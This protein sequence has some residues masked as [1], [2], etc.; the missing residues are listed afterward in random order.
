MEALDQDQTMKVQ[1]TSE[2][3]IPCHTWNLEKS[4]F[5]LPPLPPLPDLPITYTGLDEDMFHQETTL[6]KIAAMDGNIIGLTNKGHLVKY[7]GLSSVQEFNEQPNQPTQWEYV[8][9]SRIFYWS[10]TLI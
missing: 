5:M 4:P 6:I 7:S 9:T 8:G 10:L 1:A 2:N 3:T